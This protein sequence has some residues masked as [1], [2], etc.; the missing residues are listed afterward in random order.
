MKF[1]KSRVM[2]IN[3]EVAETFLVACSCSLLSILDSQVEVPFFCVTLSILG[4]PCV[5][6]VVSLLNRSPIISLCILSEVRC[7]IVCLGG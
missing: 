1:S 4:L 2:G 6:Y 7:G 3:L 5:V